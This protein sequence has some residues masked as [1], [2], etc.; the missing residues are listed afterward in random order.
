MF[1]GLL[2]VGLFSLYPLLVLIN[3][4]IDELI[5]T[6][7]ILPLSISFFASV[8][9]YLTLSQ[10]TKSHN[11]SALFVI[12]SIFFF[13]YYGHVFHGYFSGKHLGEITVGRHRFFFPL[14]CLLYLIFCIVLI[15]I[16]KSLD[17]LLKFLSYL[18]LILVLSVL[19]PNI[20]SL[21]SSRNNDFKIDQ[22]ENVKKNTIAENSQFKDKRPDIYYI[23]LD[24]YAALETLKN[25]YQY[26]NSK[27][28]NSLNER[29]FFIAE[30]SVAN[31]S[32]T[33]LSLSSTLN[34]MYMD[35]LGESN[36]QK[37]VKIKEIGDTIADN[38]VA[39]L[40]KQYGYK[41]VTFDSGYS[42]SSRSSISD[43]KVSCATL[44]EFDRTL[45]RTTIL[46]PFFLY[47]GVRDMIECQFDSLK[48]E[49]SS[50]S[51]FIFSHIVAPHPPFV[52]NSTGG[53]VGMNSGLNPWAD[54]DAY[55]EQLQFVNNKIIEVIDHIQAKNVGNELI[56]IL[57]S[58]HGPAS[59]G[60]EE[61]LNPSNDLIKERMRIL[62]AYF[63][64]AK[65]KNRLYNNITPVNSFRLIL[66]E[67][68]GLDLPL[69]E[70]RNF[71]TPIGQEKLIFKDVSEIAGYE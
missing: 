59:L 15:R 39:K 40:L 70:D 34:M 55:V 4:N 60:T 25:F 19:I 53:K 43:F 57:Q 42:T 22:L 49:F 31:H 23:V 38:K 2:A 62:N 33:Y 24:G 52:F 3:A 36:D 21:E 30:K 44:S 50:D 32:Y 58:D 41:Y 16:R 65:I 45:I 37:Q 6:D 46:D 68:I 67:V 12:I 7:A 63:V 9:A 10:L 51:K 48:N 66:S 27:F 1:R 28:Y 5:I 54:K 8:A 26:D 69:L 20:V 29:G 61:M 35:W 17:I 11:K 18:F 47:G 71:F 13:F 14:W 64:P 56:M